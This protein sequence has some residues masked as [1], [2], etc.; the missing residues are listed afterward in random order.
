MIGSPSQK[1]ILRQMRALLLRK[2]DVTWTRP[3]ALL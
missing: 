1:L 3:T 2:Y